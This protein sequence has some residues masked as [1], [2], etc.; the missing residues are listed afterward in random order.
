[1]AR[2]PAPQTQI[3]EGERTVVVPRNPPLPRKLDQLIGRLFAVSVAVDIRPTGATKACELRIHAGFT[4]IREGRYFGPDRILRDLRLEM[5]PACGAV[6]VRDISYDRISGLP[7]GR[8]GP[9]RRDLVLG[10]YSGKRPASR[11]F[12]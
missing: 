6:C 10:W 11:Q 8:G 12:S 1:M 2:T 3:I 9:R 7:I 4:T 5:C